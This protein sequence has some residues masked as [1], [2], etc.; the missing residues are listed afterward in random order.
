MIVFS[1]LAITLLAG[2][3]A[4]LSVGAGGSSNPY[5]LPT[6]ATAAANIPTPTPPPPPPIVLSGVAPGSVFA[7]TDAFT[8]TIAGDKFTPQTRVYVDNQEVPTTFTSAQQLAAQIPAPL[9]SAPGTRQVLVRT[10]DGQLYSNPLSFNVAEPPKPQ[11]TYVG[12][13]G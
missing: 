6:D 7:Q 2:P 5:E 1:L 10:P 3:R 12:L 11:F 4:E 8:L 9:I 13:L